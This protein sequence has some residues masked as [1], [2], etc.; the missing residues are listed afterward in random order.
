MLDKP[1]IPDEATAM[2]VASILLESYLGSERFEHFQR[3]Q[4]LVAQLD[5]DVWSVFSHHPPQVGPDGHPRYIMGGGGPCI[6]LDRN[7]ARVV[8]LYFQR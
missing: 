1:M 6:R 3:T 5:G 2:K 7:D 8:Q 4:P